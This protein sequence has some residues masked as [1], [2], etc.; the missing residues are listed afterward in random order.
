MTFSHT[1]L[2]PASGTRTGLKCIA[3]A[4]GG[5]LERITSL[6]GTRSL[7]YFGDMSRLLRFVR[8]ILHLAPQINRH[9]PR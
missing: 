3:V 1:H 5:L 4:W 8:L 7:A 2:T 9:F 6:R